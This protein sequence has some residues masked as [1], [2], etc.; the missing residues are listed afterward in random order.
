M[1]FALA[2]ELFHFKQG[3]KISSITCRMKG[4]WIKPYL[5][6]DPDYN[7]SLC[8]FIS[9]IQ[10]VEMANVQALGSIWI[11]MQ[12]CIAAVLL[13]GVWQLF[14]CSADPNVPGDNHIQL[15]QSLVYDFHLETGFNPAA[16][17][18]GRSL[19]ACGPVFTHPL[20][21]QIGFSAVHTNVSPFSVMCDSLRNIIF[22][23]L[24]FYNT[25][26]SK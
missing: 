16:V 4:F 25:K 21:L 26:L 2:P 20:W 22:S 1:S 12:E 8:I 3:S 18:Q 14:I 9:L 10:P 11:V 24:P 17:L 13:Q 6:L 15:C 23:L 5:Y 19:R 7:F